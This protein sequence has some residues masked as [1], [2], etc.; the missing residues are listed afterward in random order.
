MKAYVGEHS[1]LLA[2]REFVAMQSLGIPPDDECCELALRSYSASRNSSGIAKM[3]RLISA[4][5]ANSSNTD[6]KP[7][8]GTMRG[9]I[10]AKSYLTLIE[11]YRALC[12]PR[13]ATATYMELK[14]HLLKLHTGD[15]ESKAP[16]QQRQQS[17]PWPSRAAVTHVAATLAAAGEAGLAREFLLT[18]AL[19]QVRLEALWSRAH[20]GTEKRAR[21]AREKLEMELTEA[22]EEARAAYSDRKKH[23]KTRVPI[24]EKRLAKMKS[25]NEQASAQILVGRE[26]VL[27]VVYESFAQAWKDMVDC[28]KPELQAAKALE[29]DGILLD[30]YEKEN[31]LFRIWAAK[32]G[33]GSSSEQLP[34]QSSVSGGD[35]ENDAILPYAASDKDVQPSDTAADHGV[36]IASDSATGVEATLPFHSSLPQPK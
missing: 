9:K 36:K 4:A 25:G 15:H 3:H 10:T 23:I 5:L 35:E 20:A 18:E 30:A 1:P 12:N 19:E 34:D 6:N 11:A 2:I 17:V 29:G 31:A 27:R 14:T 33:S 8:P 26:G 24:L 16:Q 21:L 13:G 32:S 28:L 7:T 22:R